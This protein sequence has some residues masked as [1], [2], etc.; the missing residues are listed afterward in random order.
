V[1]FDAYAWL[2]TDP[3]TWVGT[4]PLAEVPDLADLPRLISLK[5]R[6]TVNRWTTLPPRRGVLL[7]V[8]TGGRLADSLSW[9]ELLSGYG[10]VDIASISLRDRYGSWGFLDL[11]RCTPEPPFTDADASLLTQVGAPITTA[12]RRAQAR[13]VLD[14]DL[15]ILQQTAPVDQHLRALLPTAPDLSPVPAAA[16]NVAAQLQAVESGADHHQPSARAHLTGGPWISVR[17]SRLTG[18]AREHGTIAITIETLALSEHVDL[19]AC[20]T[21]LTPRERQLLH[22]L[23]NGADN[24]TIARFMIISLFTV[25]D[26]LKSIYAKSGARTRTELIAQAAAGRRAV[27]A[28]PG[29]SVYVRDR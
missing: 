14:D 15:Q 19:F 27:P 29:Q 10:V 5:Y 9:R 24:A 23:T 3:R 26:H 4:S 16:L 7:S 17:A 22:L 11:W 20:V 6:T 25:Q 2:L 21:V 13:L 8:T 18:P 12:L 1:G 28:D